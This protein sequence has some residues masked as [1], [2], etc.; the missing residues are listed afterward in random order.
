MGFWKSGDLGD[1]SYIRKANVSIADF[2]STSD[3]LEL[4]VKLQKVEVMGR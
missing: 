4:I 2:L 1:L 3:M